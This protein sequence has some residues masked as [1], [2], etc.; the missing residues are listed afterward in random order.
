MT[1]RCSRVA[2]LGLCTLIGPAFG[3]MNSKV[4]LHSSSRRLQE[5]GRNESD[6]VNAKWQCEASEVWMDPRAKNLHWA[7]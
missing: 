5:D 1:P 3:H 4:N 6:S 7:G 2:A